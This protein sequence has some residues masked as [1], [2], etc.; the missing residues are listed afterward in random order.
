VL[1][2][3]REDSAG[4]PP[5]D[6]EMS[7]ARLAGLLDAVTAAGSRVTLSCDG[8]EQELPPAV[9]HV[10]YRILQESLTNVL[11]HTPPGTPAEVR[12]HYA[13]DAVTIT[14]TDDGDGDGN[15]AGG[16]REAG[17]GNG[18]QGMRE[19]AAS[20]RGTLRA[21]PRPGGGFTVTATLPTA[22]A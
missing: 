8:A 5:A 18:I 9:D 3:L 13:P 11:R 10:A 6:R 12:L 14:V 21:G 19:R 20:V 22:A 16:R 15:G 7:L 2:Q 4:R 17:P 1:G